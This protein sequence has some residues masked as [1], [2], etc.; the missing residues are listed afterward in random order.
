MG[1][2][3]GLRGGVSV[4]EILGDVG[5][6]NSQARLQSTLLHQLRGAIDSALDYRVLYALDKTP[7]YLM[8]RGI[9]ALCG[10]ATVPVTFVIGQRVGGLAVALPAAFLVALN[11][12]HIAKSQVI[13]VDVPMTLLAALCCY[14]ALRI[15]AE[16]R[17]RDYVLAG[18]AGGLATSTK[19]N[20]ALLALPIL[21]AHVLS[22]GRRPPADAAARRGGT[23]GG[24]RRGG[25]STAAPRA[26]A[27]GFD[28]AAWGNLAIAAI[29]FAASFLLTS[30][31]VFLDRQ[32][33]WIGFNYERLHMRIGHFGLDQTPAI[34]YYAKVLTGSLLGWPL[35]LLAAAGL[36]LFIVRRRG[37]AFVLAVFPVVYVALISSFAMKAERYVLPIL[38]IA[39]VF[40]TALVAQ[41]AARLRQKRAWLPTAAMAIATLAMVVPSLVAYQRDLARLRGD[42]RTLACEW[43]E[44]NVPAGSFVATEPYGPEPIGII[45]MQNLAP[46]VRERIRKERPDTKVYALFPLPMYQVRSENTG[47]FYD[48]ALYRDVADVIV[49][50][51]S[52]SSRYRKNPTLFRPQVAFYDSLESGWRKAREFGPADGS[53]PRI[54]IYVNPRQTTAFAQRRS[55]AVPPAPPVVPDLLPGSFAG[56]F[57]RLGYIYEAYGFGEAAAQIYQQGLRYPDQ[58][59]E[60]RRSLGLG[61]IRGSI[62]ARRGAQALAILDQLERLSP[63]PSET[64]YWRA[65]RTQ[66]TAPARPDTAAARTGSR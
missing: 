29:V 54:S 64:A 21:F 14:F 58:P 22:F 3:G 39:A 5:L 27:A 20:G 51:S 1:I 9:S 38:P 11:Q 50:S 55:V 43:I 18:L 23:A 13:E 47:I 19:Y 12:T 53:G 59:A 52:V 49:T 4:Q 62:A 35:A 16:P 24:G 40:A 57:E 36:V 7:F 48:I 56:W 2:A 6:G 66:I 10:A 30:P 17:R 42:T 15:L 25:A 45:D 41:Q 32:N 34:L 28:A 63:S 8:G 65:V 26:G 46:D 33:F 44:A 60:S 61:A 37:W 31:Y